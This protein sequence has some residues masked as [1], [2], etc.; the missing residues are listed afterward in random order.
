VYLTCSTTCCL[1]DT[2]PIH[3]MCICIISNV[4][5]LKFGESLVKS[6]AFIIIIIIIIIIIAEVVIVAVVVPS[7]RKR[8]LV[9]LLDFLSNKYYMYYCTV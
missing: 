5:S 2:L 6:A 9:I 7:G 8:S 1:Y 4:Q 3:G